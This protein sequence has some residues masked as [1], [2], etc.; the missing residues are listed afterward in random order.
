MHTLIPSVFAG[1]TPTET[2]AT[3]ETTSHDYSRADSFHCV[4]VHGTQDPDLIKEAA[5]PLGRNQGQ[6]NAI[7]F[8]ENQRGEV[9]TDDIAG[10][11]TTPGGK[12]GQ[13]Y[14]A[15]AFKPSHYTRGKDGAPSAVSPPLSADADKGDQEAVIQVAMQ[16]R[17]LTP[18]ECE[19]LQGFPDN[20]TRIPYRNKAAE[21]CPDGPRYKALG[22]SMAVPV[23]RWI[24]ERIQ[25]VDSIMAEEKAIEI[26]SD[27]NFGG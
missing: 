24:G 12:P 18:V 15:V 10:T 23:M 6:E 17:R 26:L 14:P 21:N 27:M 19:R 25:K 8:M 9:R 22:N 20:Y 7:A 16:V 5:H 13:G 1:N 3:L 2:A 4:T 11:I